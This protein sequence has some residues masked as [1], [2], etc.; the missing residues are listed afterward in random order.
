M[1][2]AVEQGGGHFGVAEH[3][4]MPHRSIGESLRLKSLTR[5]IPSMGTAIRLASD[6]LGGARA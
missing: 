5:G 3:L 2:Q 1:R 4:E 6:G